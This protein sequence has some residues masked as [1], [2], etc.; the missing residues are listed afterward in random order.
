MPLFYNPKC[1]KNFK[2]FISN[3]EE[4]LYFILYKEFDKNLYDE[5]NDCVSRYYEFGLK[6]INGQEQSTNLLENLVSFFKLKHYMTLFEKEE[7]NNTPKWQYL[8]K[9]YKQ[10]KALFN[11]QTDF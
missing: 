3:Y 10:Y 8:E 7:K 11:L 2:T 6:S 5:V 4:K 1:L 9:W